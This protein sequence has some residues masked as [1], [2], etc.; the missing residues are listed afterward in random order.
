[1]HCEFW[2]RDDSDWE[3]YQSREMKRT[4]VEEFAQM[5]PY[6]N[7]VMCGGEPMLDIE[8]YFSICKD[9]RDN[10]LRVIS[11]ING[12][13]VR[14]AKTA[15]RMIQEGPHEISVSLNSHTQELHDKTRGV[16]GAFEKALTAL[17]LLLEARKRHPN[18]DTKIY[19]MGLIMKSNYLDIPAFYDFVLNEIGAD[20][21]KLNFIQPSFGQNQPTDSFFAVET[22]IDP[23]RL[24]EMID[25]SQT[26]YDLD[27]NPTW[28]K[29]VTMYFNS[30]AKK[31]DL[32]KGWGTS[33]GTKK[34]I[35]NSYDRNIMVDQYGYA[36]LC[37]SSAFKGMQIE[38]PGDLKKF[39]NKMNFERL[40]MK[41]C[42]QFCGISHSV[43][44]ASSTMGGE[45]KIAEFKDLTKA[46]FPEVSD[47]GILKKVLTRAGK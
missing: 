1:M 35:C 13:R 3:N 12:T 37:Y 46:A 6:G 17:R 19:V 27:Y 11:V 10:G 18:S 45:A 26:M 47:T 44:A 32:Q 31:K 23:V 30:L 36:R 40:K 25:Q 4:V 34:A 29:N 22:D 14:S 16:E 24:D 21:L 38:K 8:E 43:R 15:D 9:G 28:R 33:T 39:W 7:V 41:S 5:S 2:R 42:K 20:K